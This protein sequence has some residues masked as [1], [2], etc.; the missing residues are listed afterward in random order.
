MYLLFQYD[1]LCGQ[2]NCQPQTLQAIPGTSCCL[3]LS[4][5]IQHFDWIIYS[6]LRSDVYIIVD[7]VK[8]S[9]LTLVGEIGC[10]RN[11]SYDDDDYC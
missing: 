9:V 6:F 5:I 8:H 3:L 10:Y 7:L 11:D 4:I 1:P 2:K